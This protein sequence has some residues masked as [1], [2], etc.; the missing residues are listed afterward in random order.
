[1]LVSSKRIQWLLY[2]WQEDISNEK[3]KLRVEID[4]FGMFSFVNAYPCGICLLLEVASQKQLLTEK[5]FMPKE[6]A[7]VPLCPMSNERPLAIV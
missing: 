2:R 3:C 5:I 6:A 7:D 1:M 4:S